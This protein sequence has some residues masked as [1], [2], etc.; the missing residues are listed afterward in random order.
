MSC[1]NAHVPEI[2]FI[3]SVVVVVFVEAVVDEAVAVACCL[4]PATPK[5]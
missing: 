5:I 2:A 3:E 4:T 1:S